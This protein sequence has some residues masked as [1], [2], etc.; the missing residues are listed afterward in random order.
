MCSIYSSIFLGQ[1]ILGA[2]SF[3]L[4]KF[5]KITEFCNFSSE[6]KDFGDI[7]SYNFNFY[8][9]FYKVSD[10]NN[11]IV[12]FFEIDNDSAEM[13]YKSLGDSI[14]FKNSIDKF[15][16]SVNSKIFLNKD[17][18][19]LFDVD[20]CSFISYFEPKNAIVEHIEESILYIRN[21]YNGVNVEG[22]PFRI[23][24]TVIDCLYMCGRHKSKR[25]FQL[26]G[27]FPTENGRTRRNISYDAFNFI[28]F[29][30]LLSKIEAYKKDI[31][32]LEIVNIKIEEYTKEAFEN[33]KPKN[34]SILLKNKESKNVSIF[35][36]E[37]FLKEKRVLSSKLIEYKSEKEILQT[38]F[39]QNNKYNRFILYKPDGIVKINKDNSYSILE[40]I[41]EDFQEVLLGFDRITNKALKKEKI[42][43]DI[44]RDRTTVTTN[45]VNMM[46]QLHMKKLS[47]IAIIVTFLGLVISISNI[48]ISLYPDDVKKC[49]LTMKEIVI[50]FL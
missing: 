47:I 17:L 29:I 10:S 46:L 6:G 44:L 23:F 12:Y 8:I 39:K 34:I 32:K 40:R 27:L 21:K 38:K 20:D 37:S 31:E 3:H 35:F 16:K 25:N 43:N 14:F 9:S 24:D 30:S 13:F 5:Q 7:K 1:C 33:E 26:I 48:F 4:S 28:D 41:I 22:R 50:R 42:I 36:K 2:K 18:L 15:L 11:T 49:I 45:D 19:N